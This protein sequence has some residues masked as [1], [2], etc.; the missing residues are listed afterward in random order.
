MRERERERGRDIYRENKIGMRRDR[1]S[2]R[3]REKGGGGG[4]N[5]FWMIIVSL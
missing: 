3:E 5:Q 4:I 1:E 2:R